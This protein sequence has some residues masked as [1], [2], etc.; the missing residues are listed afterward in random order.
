[1]DWAQII[2]V[3]LSIMLGALVVAAIGLVVSFLLL[4][5]KIRQTASDARSLADNVTKLKMMIRTI[6]SATTGAK[7]IIRAIKQKKGASDGKRR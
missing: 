3:L 7:A 1:M 6:A 2:V 5:H 4:T